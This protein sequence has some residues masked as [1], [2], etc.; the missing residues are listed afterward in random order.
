MIMGQ[1]ISCHEINYASLTVFI[2]LFTKEAVIIAQLSSLKCCNS[3][4]TPSI[5]NP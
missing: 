2:Y 4:P 3:S 5:S 1:S